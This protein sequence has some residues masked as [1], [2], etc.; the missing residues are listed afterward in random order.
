MLG[1]HKNEKAMSGEKIEPSGAKPEDKTSSREEIFRRQAQ[2]QGEK[3]G[4][5]RLHQVT[6]E[7]WQEEDDEEGGLLRDRFLRAINIGRR[8]N[9]LQAKRTQKE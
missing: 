9:L 5:Y 7:R 1:E 3:G 6:Q 4:I 2:A 8:V